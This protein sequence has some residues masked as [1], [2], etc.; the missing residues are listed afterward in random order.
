M[1]TTVTEKR[2]GEKLVKI[3]L[4]TCAAHIC[5]GTAYLLGGLGWSL[6]LASEKVDALGDRVERR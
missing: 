5:K 4:R 2:K 1:P 3:A 6:Y